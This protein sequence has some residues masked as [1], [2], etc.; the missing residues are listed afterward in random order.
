MDTLNA[1]AMG[2][3]TRGQEAM[4]F[5]WEKAATLLASRRIKSASAGLCGDWDYTGGPILVDGEPVKADDGR[6]YLSSTWATPQIEIDGDVIDCYRMQGEVPHWNSK[7]FWPPEAL[8]I[9]NRLRA[10][11]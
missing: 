7:T 10:A 2:R 1:F 6:C 9:F 5:D 11:T 8:A 4:V 3:A